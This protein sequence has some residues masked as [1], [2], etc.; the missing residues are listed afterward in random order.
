MKQA[1]RLASNFV[2]LDDQFRADT[3]EVTPDLYER[4]DEEYK[5]FAG[6]LLISNYTFDADWPTWEV[7][8]AGDEFV[9]LL[10]GEADLVLAKDD[11]DVTIAMTEPG[12]FVI[13]PQNTWHTARVRSNAVMMFITPGEGTINAAEPVRGAD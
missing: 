3:L 12:T 4:L 8:P 5:E 6:H 10:S 9:I 1:L 13:V 7:H 2:V 11:G